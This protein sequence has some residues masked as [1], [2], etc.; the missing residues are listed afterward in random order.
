MHMIYAVIVC[1]MKPKQNSDSLQFKQ[2]NAC[3]I[4]NAQSC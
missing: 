4:S 1:I 2:F 3:A